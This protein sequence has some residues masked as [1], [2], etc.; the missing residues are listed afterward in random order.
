MSGI[1]AEYARILGMKDTLIISGETWIFPDDSYLGFNAVLEHWLDPD[2]KLRG[3]G[4]VFWN[5]LGDGTHFGW[6]PTLGVKFRNRLTV[7]VNVAF[8]SG[9]S[10]SVGAIV[11][12]DYNSY[13]A[14]I[15]EKDRQERLEKKEEGRTASVEMGQVALLE[16]ENGYYTTLPAG[17]G[18]IITQETLA[19]E[20]KKHKEGESQ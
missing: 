17:S 12:Y 3:G 1:Y 11:G 5:F 2:W 4:T 16:S 8:L 13:L 6:G 7:G 20:I 14:E 19:E 15:M 10:T 9:G 18:V